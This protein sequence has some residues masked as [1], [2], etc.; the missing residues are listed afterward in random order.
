MNAITETANAKINLALHI[1]RRRD[2]GYHD[3][4]TLFAFVDDGDRLE[5]SPAAKFQLLFDGEF[6][7]LIEGEGIES[8]LVTRSARALCGGTLPDVSVKLTKNLP[9]AAG[10]G[11]G[12]ADAAAIIRGLARHLNFDNNNP[13]IMAIAAELGADI[14]ACIQ[15][16]P[17]LGKGTGT[18]LSPVINDVTGLSCLLINP[19]IALSTARVFKAWRES[20][21][22]ALPSGTARHI[23]E[24]GRNDLEDAAKSLCP[25]IA[26]ILTYLNETKPIIARMSGSGATCFALYDDHQIAQQ[27]ASELQISHPH[28]WHMIGRLR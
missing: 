28:W 7:G 8:N 12:S 14:P 26:E 27:W 9:I 6:G 2:D 20:D 13:E 18:D 3:L 21:L 19:R 5:I 11:G 23:L 24:Y 1:C 22:G 16:V 4:D 17:V 10:L 25:Q 15:S